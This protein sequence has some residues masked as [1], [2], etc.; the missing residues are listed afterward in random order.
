[1]SEAKTVSL[2]RLITGL[3]FIAIGLAVFLVRIQHAGTYAIPSAGVLLGAMSS[4]FLG[5]L[6]IWPS[7]PRL[8]MWIALAVSPVAVFVSIYSIVGELEEVISLYAPNSKG[9]VTDLRLWV[10]DR[11]DGAWV[12]MSRD[13]AIE[14]S[15][16]GARLEM[17][18]SGEIHC[19]V[20]ALSQSQQT[21]RTIHAMKIKKY[22]AAQMAAGIGLY[23]REATENTAA[24]RL[25]PCDD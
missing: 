23:P 20:P 11:D 13:K 24:L 25:D 5:A 2:T 21:T 16:D 15:L 6:L 22:A 10:V 12:G 9:Q 17:L 19:V 18:R 14:H 4:T 3:T 8:I 1:M 7:V